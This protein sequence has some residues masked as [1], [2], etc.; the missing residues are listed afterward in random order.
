MSDKTPR[1]YEA[2]VLAR[3]SELERKAASMET[4]V[5]ETATNHERLA[6]AVNLASTKISELETILNGNQRLRVVGAVRQVDDL[7]GRIDTIE[8]ERQS[9]KDQLK[10]IR[11]V[12]IFLG[13]TNIG[14]VTAFFSSIF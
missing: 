5:K 3:V 11:Y 8:Q 13:L 2:S 4:L 7:T 14:T 6:D 12:A 1:P 9:Q 10:G